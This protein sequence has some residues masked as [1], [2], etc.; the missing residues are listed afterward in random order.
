MAIILP[1]FNLEGSWIDGHNIQWPRIKPT[2]TC[3]CIILQIK[4]NWECCDLLEDTKTKCHLVQ[5]KFFKRNYGYF[6]VPR[7]STVGLLFAC[8]SKVVECYDL[9]TKERVVC[10]HYMY[11]GRN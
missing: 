1:Y 5:D 9:C 7:K 3:S 4:K 2:T 11:R 8:D 10:T 6:Y